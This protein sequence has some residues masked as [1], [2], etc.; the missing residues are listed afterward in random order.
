MGERHPLHPVITDIPITAWLLT[1]SLIFSGWPT[2]LRRSAHRASFL[3][4]PRPDT[5]LW[6]LCLGAASS[7]IW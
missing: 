6:F 7:S 3:L 4:L 5:P 1:A 2:T